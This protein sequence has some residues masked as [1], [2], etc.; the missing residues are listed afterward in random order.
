LNDY[1]GRNLPQLLDL[2][3]EVVTPEPVSWLPQTVGWW[4][5]AGWLSALVLLGALHGYLKWRR[6]RYRRDAL[7]ELRAIEQQSP[8]DNVSARSIAELLK[9]TALAAYP[10]EQVAPL[11]GAEWAGFLRESAGDDEIVT[12]EAERL[13]TMAYRPDSDVSTLI[14][15]ARRWI[16]VHRA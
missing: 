5:V 15:P 1:E 16:E 13:A 2:M 8:I 6:N 12:A 10:R 7:A 3:H 14:R 11:Y 4:V 9:R